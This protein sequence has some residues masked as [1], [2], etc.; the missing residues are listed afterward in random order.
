M[1]ASYSR[2]T[3]RFVNRSVVKL[4][5]A[6]IPACDARPIT[7]IAYRM[8][9]RNAVPH[10]KVSLN[11]QVI[12]LVNF[13]M[14]FDIDHTRSWCNARS[15]RTLR[16]RHSSTN[17]TRSRLFLGYATGSLRHNKRRTLFVGLLRQRSAGARRQR[18]ASRMARLAHHQ[19]KTWS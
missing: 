15:R 7:T 18:T 5:R 10:C 4:F 19:A 17:L 11:P 2:K 12:L 16:Y 3:L 14:P 13:N 9:A 6:R 1:M 8:V